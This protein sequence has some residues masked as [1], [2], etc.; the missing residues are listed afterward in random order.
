MSSASSHI[1]SLNLPEWK[2]I[3]SNV[4]I[5][6]NA[7]ATEL[8]VFPYTQHV[9]RNRTRPEGAMQQVKGAYPPARIS[10]VT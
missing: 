6:F 8:K 7:L 2:N 4:S 1:G 9:E 3:H 10:L 5:N